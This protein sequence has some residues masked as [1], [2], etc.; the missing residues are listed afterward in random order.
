MASRLVVS[1]SSAYQRRC[2]QFGEPGVE[3]G[4]GENGFVVD[5]MVTAVILFGRIGLG[6]R[7]RI[8][9]AQPGPEFVALEQRPQRVGVARLQH[10]IVEIEGQRHVA[11]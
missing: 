11:S 9:L 10:E 6:G 5:A 1:V 4:L 7:G 2:V 8:E 3:L